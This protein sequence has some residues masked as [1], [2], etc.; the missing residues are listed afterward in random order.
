M[1][2][3]DGRVATLWGVRGDCVLVCFRVT[4]DAGGRVVA[5]TVADF[6]DLTGRPDCDQAVRTRLRERY[7]PET[8]C[9]LALDG[10]AGFAQFQRA[11]L[12]GREPALS[13]R[14]S[15]TSPGGKNTQLGLWNPDT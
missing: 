1:S 2:G 12:Q 11:L 10:G 15:P 6:D 14:T 9:S 5:T 8:Q 7:G 4:V 3:A 13:Q